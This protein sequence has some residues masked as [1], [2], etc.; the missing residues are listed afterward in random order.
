MPQV[1]RAADGAQARARVQ[2]ALARHLFRRYLMIGEVGARSRVA[3]AGQCG[4]VADRRLLARHGRCNP[5]CCHRSSPSG[6]SA[7]L[8]ADRARYGKMRATSCIRLV[9]MLAGRRVG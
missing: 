1:L 7:V 6:R 5:L 2:V 9:R 3:R 4:Q 8:S